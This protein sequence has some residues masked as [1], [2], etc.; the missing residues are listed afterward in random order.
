[1][2]EVSVTDREDRCKNISDLVQK[3]PIRQEHY[4]RKCVLYVLDDKVNLNLYDLG[5]SLMFTVVSM[6]LMIC[7]LACIMPLVCMH[8]YEETLRRIIQMVAFVS[9]W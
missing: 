4:A 3:S 6:N 9:K 8:S 5:V 2:E 1:M 7:S